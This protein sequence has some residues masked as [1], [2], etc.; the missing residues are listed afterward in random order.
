MTQKTVMVRLDL[1]LYE[2]LERE[3]R[4]RRISVSQIIEERLRRTFAGREAA[5]TELD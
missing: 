4:E 5:V 2:T 1:G 3:A